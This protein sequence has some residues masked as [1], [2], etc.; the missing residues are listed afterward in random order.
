[1]TPLLKASLWDL[2]PSYYDVVINLNW[3][4]YDC[5][6]ANSVETSRNQTETEVIDCK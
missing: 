4:P 3:A 2:G 5:S 1:M 6:M